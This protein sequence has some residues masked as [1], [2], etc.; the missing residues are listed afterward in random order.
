MLVDDSQVIR[1]IKTID[2][3]NLD[4]EESQKIKVSLS[5]ANFPAAMKEY[6]S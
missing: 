2:S 5:A 6:N 3:P 4:K 1:N